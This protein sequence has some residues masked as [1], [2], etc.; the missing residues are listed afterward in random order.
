MF[1]ES[2]VSKTIDINQGCILTDAEIAHNSEG[3]RLFFE[4]DYRTSTCPLPSFAE[5]LIHLRVLY[6]TVLECFPHLVDVVM[7]ILSCSPKRKQRE[8]TGTIQLAWG[9]HVVFPSIVTTTPIMKLIA[10]L[11]DTRISNLFPQWTSIVDPA[12]YRSSSATLRPCYSYKWIKCPICGI[13]ASSTRVDDGPTTT[14]RRRADVDMT[15][16]SVFRKQLSDTCSCFSGHRVDPSIYTYSGSLVRSDGPLVQMLQGIQTVLKETSITPSR[17]GTF[18]D[19]FR[20]PLDMGDEHDV[21]PQSGVLFPS[22]HR[23]VSGFQPR[24]NNTPLKLSDYS[25]GC[26]TILE[27]IKRVHVNYQCLAIHRISVDPK[28]QSFLINVKGNGSRYCMYRKRVHSSNGVYF[29]LDAKR[30]RI[31][32][33]CFDPDCKRDHAKAHIERALS[34]VDKYS[35]TTQFEL[36]NTR[37]RPTVAQC[38]PL[39]QLVPLV[40]Q[41]PLIPLEPVQQIQMKKL[42]WEEKRRMYQSVTGGQ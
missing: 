22:K 19:G 13:K 20:R 32:V 27:I 4:L 15:I 42:K 10:Q 21:I 8:S 14:K 5:A 37:T 33:L 9:I 16:E 1:L 39:V 6:R 30:A 17:I 38:V 3:V 26:R 24:K 23:A 34:L 11:L 25:T 12:S 7:H 29:C 2:F 18:T 28:T 35:I 40:P 41:V 36:R 31:R